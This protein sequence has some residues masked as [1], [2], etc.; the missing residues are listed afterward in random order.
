MKHL[1]D[2]KESSAHRL[3][4]LAT[5]SALASR[6]FDVCQCHNQHQRD[7]KDYFQLLGWLLSAVSCR[8]PLD[9]AAVLDVRVASEHEQ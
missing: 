8:N 5:L 1:V 9:V 6:K 3:S 2:R 4:A 7:A